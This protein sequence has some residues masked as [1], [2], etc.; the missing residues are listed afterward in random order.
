MFSLVDVR[1][2]FK[3]KTTSIR[4]CF[5]TLNSAP[6]FARRGIVQMLLGM[7]IFVIGKIFHDNGCKMERRFSVR[8]HLS[9]DKNSHVYQQLGEIFI[10]SPD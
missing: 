9:T 3:F 5:E 6:A 4:G 1:R 8:D 7:R 2:F 10:Q